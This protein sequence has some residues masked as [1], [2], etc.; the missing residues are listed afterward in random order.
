MANIA[1][2]IKANTGKALGEFKKLSRE[3]DNKFLVQGL[4]LDVVKNAFRQ[5][6]KEFDTALGDQGFKTSESTNQLQRNAAANLAAL[7]K[8]G[9][10]AAFSITK[11][12]TNSLRDL[13]AQGEITNEALKETLN[14]AGFFDFSGSDAQIAAQFDSFSRRF[15]KFAT[16][17]NDAFGKSSAGQL[18]QV[19]TGKASPDT[20]LNLDFGAGG[21]GA[22]VISK[23]LRE[24]AGG[25]IQNLSPEIRTQIAEQLFRDIRDDTT[26]VGKVYKRATEQARIDDPFRFLKREISSIFSEKGVFGSL[27]TLSEDAKF[28]NL[29]GDTVPENVLQ[30]SANLLNVIFNK[31]EGL[32]AVLFKSLQDVFGEGD[33]LAPII[34]GIKLLTRALRAVSRFFASDE[35]KSFLEVFKPLADTIRNIDVSNI[36]ID[37]DTIKGFI[38]NIG[39]AIRELFN[40]SAEFIRKLDTK[41][42]SEV[43]GTIIKELVKTI[44]SLL[45]LVFSSL[46]KI[47]GVLFD[48][49]NSSGGSATLIYSAIIAG[50]VNFADKLFGGPGLV[51]RI[52]NILL[53][54]F[55]RLA[56]ALRLGAGSG[57]GASRTNNQ[58]V[59]DAR[60]NRVTGLFNNRVIRSLNTII[61]LLGGSAPLDPSGRG[62]GGPRRG[63]PGRD[64]R[65]AS[66]R[67]RNINRIR[68]SRR[69]T[70]IT[71]RIPGLRQLR[72]AQLARNFLGGAPRIP[73]A[74][75]LSQGRGLS[76]GRLPGDY[77]NIPNRNNARIGSPA[78]LFQE[79]APRIP[80]PARFSNPVVPRVPTVP[81]V[82]LKP[83][84]NP[85]AFVPP[86]A[87][88]FAAPRLP[89][90]PRVPSA[91]AGGILSRLGSTGRGVTRGLSGGLR[92][93]PLL[94]T[95]LSGL[96]IAS[97]VGGPGASAAEMEGLTPEQKREQRRQDERG[98]TRGVL[99]VLGGVG[100]GAAGGAALGTL[101]GGPVGTIIGGII[102]GIVGEEAVKFLSDPIIDGITDFGKG[103]GSFFSGLWKGTSQLFGDGWKAVTNFFGPEG[104]IQSTFKFVVELPGKMVGG[105]KEGFEAIR[106]KVVG[107][108]ATLWKSITEG[109]TGKQPEAPTPERFLGGVGR[110]M[111]LV[112]ENGPELVNLGSGSVVTPMTSF[113]GLGLNRGGSSGQTTNN[114]VINVNAP[115]ADEFADQLS[116]QVIE[117][118]DEMLEEQKTLQGK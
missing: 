38:G 26:E 71:S 67:A 9:V 28:T 32:F 40:K 91:G 37:L 54:S 116:V 24:K 31:N 27:R 72:S 107:L 48:T 103:V 100:G 43:L 79:R 39:N 77:R 34:G 86:A 10:D 11:N 101:V 46:G 88:R 115:G 8:L 74:S 64:G 106:D 23:Y 42:V 82:P 108:P 53:N 57:R 102:G 47:I 14:V 73:G 5:I 1:L 96:A 44:P 76:V 93:I 63:A 75:V 18:Q 114:V 56:A 58:R 95:L 89:R 83:I 41:A 94:G 7:N 97:I 3:L 15:A 60:A 22:N 85:T 87:P 117:K 45:N 12:M 29:S 81:R 112:G 13:Q 105:I 36:T 66:Q 4:K 49:I 33:P 110:G 111:T 69:I 80:R 2:D 90:V 59:M 17:T 16:D 68:R 78:S 30:L 55:S 19:L 65:T 70:G 118:L 99:G 104:P 62:R 109:F 35:F 92:R 6:T 25:N 50:F 61:R 84:V 52:R 21:A 98:K 113:A 20:L 51:G